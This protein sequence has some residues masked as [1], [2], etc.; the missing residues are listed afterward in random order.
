MLWH[1]WSIPALTSGDRD[2]RNNQLSGSLDIGTGHGN[3]LAL[4]D[5]RKNQISG[6]TNG[7]GGEAGVSVM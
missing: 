2:A 7:L 6:Y 5:L 1:G 3:Q 4:I